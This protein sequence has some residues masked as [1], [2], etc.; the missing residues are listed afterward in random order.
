MGVRRLAA[1]A[2][3]PL[4]LL[5]LSASASASAACPGDVVAPTS[6]TARDAALAVVCD[7]NVIRAEHGLRPLRSDWR[8]S[9][10]AQRM[11]AD[12]ASHQ[13]FSHVTP[14]GRRLVDRIAPTGYTRATS[15]LLAENLGWGS[16]ELSSPLEIV[17]GWMD[18][19]AHRRNVLDPALRDVG[20]GV[21]EGAVSEGGPSGMIYVADFGSRATARTSVHKRGRGVRSRRR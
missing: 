11:A 20:V 14:D 12:M 19:P 1:A 6:D 21:V 13:Y 5:A 7:L 18:S 9:N 16:N 4:V 17:L 10:G 15:V 2:A 8:L 3:V